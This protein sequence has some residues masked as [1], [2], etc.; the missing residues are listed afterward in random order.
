MSLDMRWL[1]TAAIYAVAPQ[2]VAAKYMTVEQS[3]AMI[4]PFADE[5]VA[6]PVQRT[7]EQPAEEKRGKRKE[8]REKVGVSGR[9]PSWLPFLFSPVSFPSPF[10]T[11]QNVL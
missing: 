1:A 5:F 10:S 7:P 3:R 6:R 2:C 9:M 8:R 11:D 4:F